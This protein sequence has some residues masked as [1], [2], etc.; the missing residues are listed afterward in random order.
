MTTTKEGSDMNDK[1]STD[2]MIISS[3]TFKMM[4]H[5]Q[6]LA[7]MEYSKLT[8]ELA[9]IRTLLYKRLSPQQPQ[10]AQPPRIGSPPVRNPVAAWGDASD[11]E[12]N[13]PMG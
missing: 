8:A 6:N 10:V 4:I 3:E 12:C 1:L 5:S 7:L 9:E 2:N 13:Q 11:Q